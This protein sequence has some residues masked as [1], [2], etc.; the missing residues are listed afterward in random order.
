MTNNDQQNKGAFQSTFAGWKHSTTVRYLL[1]VVL[2]VMLYAGMAPKLLPE[3]YDIA[4]GL[5]SDKEILAPM[6]IPDTKATLKAQEDAAEKVGQVYTILPLRNE[7]LVGQLLDRIFRL[8]QDDQVSEDDKIQIYREE[9][10]QRVKDYVQTFIMNNRNNSAYSATLF[11]EVTQRIDEQQYHISEETFIKIPRLTAEDINEMKPVA[12][13]IV[14]RLTA[15][16]IVDAQTART[17]V[18]EM[19]STSSLSKRTSREVVQELARLSI[20][21]NKF[22]DEE[23]TKAAKVEARENT[24]TVYIKQGD[25]LVKRVRKSPRK[26]IPC[27]RKTGC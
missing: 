5:P 12:A 20:T 19:V 22:Y 13:D 9:L 25:V 14:A 1:Y 10:P 16:S 3:T 21:A 6:D 24:P 17:K 4:V 11:E 2:V 27:W 15:D 26:C 8:N 23:A 18:A 7:A